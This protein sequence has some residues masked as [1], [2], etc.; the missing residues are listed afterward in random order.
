MK[1][2]LTPSNRGVHALIALDV[3]LDQL[4]LVAE[5][6]QVRAIARRE[7]VENPDLVALRAQM[8]RKVRAD[9]SAASRYQRSHAFN[10]TRPCSV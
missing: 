3:A 10:T 6:E 9:E 4:D 1:D 8:P 2:D 5:R 7:V